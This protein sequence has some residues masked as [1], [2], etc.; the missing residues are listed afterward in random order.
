M[1]RT[2]RFLHSAGRLARWPDALVPTPRSTGPLFVIVNF[3]GTFLA[4]L[5]KGHMR[6]PKRLIT[7]LAL[8]LACL[9]TNVTVAYPLDLDPSF[10]NGGTVVVPHF[11]AIPGFDDPSAIGYWNIPATI[12]LQPD[13][14]VLLA[15]EIRQCFPYDPFGGSCQRGGY[16]ALVRYNSDGSVDS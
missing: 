8:L 11:G 10:G 6:S 14:K 13:G 15:I 7:T 5:A 12:A 2:E 9:S 3:I 16:V 1:Q 4:A